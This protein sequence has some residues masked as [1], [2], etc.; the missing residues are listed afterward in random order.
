MLYSSYQYLY[1]E[2]G[3]EIKSRFDLDLVLDRSMEPQFNQSYDLTDTHGRYASSSAGSSSSE[4]HP[5]G[6]SPVI[7]RVHDS[8]ASTRASASGSGSEGGRRRQMPPLGALTAYLNGTHL[9]DAEQGGAAG[10]RTEEEAAAGA[11]NRASPSVPTSSKHP[12]RALPAVSPSPRSE[13]G[14]TAAREGLARTGSRAST[15]SPSL[16]AQTSRASAGRSGRS[17]AGNGSTDGDSSS[18]SPPE[19]PSRPSFAAGS[20]HHSHLPDLP[21]PVVSSSGRV[22]PPRSVAS[23]ASTVRSSSLLG[24]V[25]SRGSVIDESAS[26]SN[27]EADEDPSEGVDAKADSLVS[28]LRAAKAQITLLTAQL[29]GISGQLKAQNGRA[30]PPVAAP[31]TSNSLQDAWDVARHLFAVTPV[32][33]TVS[34]PPSLATLSLALD[35]A[36]AMDSLVHGSETSDGGVE[37]PARRDEEVF[38]EANLEAVL[39]KARSWE[40]VVRR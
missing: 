1:L 36:R 24:K 8:P 9:E 2:N 34:D 25:P 27:S 6:A 10:N 13:R 3:G 40:R 4:R 20:P 23:A 26:G 21:T 19:S 14:G 37:E 39:D 16:R 5:R 7:R 12:R 35:F 17:R 33:P 15:P 32:P 31:Q 18:H 38:T 29:E 28:K 30:V 11:S 22:R